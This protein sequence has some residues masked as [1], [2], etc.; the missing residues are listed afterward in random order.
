M[1]P[2]WSVC[3]IAKNE[4]KTLPRLLNSLEEFISLGGEVIL[5]DTGSTDKTVKIAKKAK[6]KV[7]EVGDKFIHYHSD[8]IIDL[9]NK[10][11]VV[12]DEA[13]IM[14]KGS[15]NFDFAAARNYVA[16]L[17]T[18][19]MVAMPDCDEVYNTLNIEEIN[20][21]IDEGVSQFNYH[22]VYAHDEYGNPTIQFYHSKFYDRRKM[23]WRGIV[24]ET[25]YQIGNVGVNM[26]TVEKN[27]IFLEH[28]QNTK[29]YRGQYLTGLAYDVFLNPDNDR[30]SH[31]LGRE[32]MFTNRFNSA[33]KELTRHINMKKWEMERCQ[34][35]LFIGDCMLWLGRAMEALQY[36]HYAYIICSTRREPFLRLAEYYY[37]RQD[38]KR[39]IAYTEASL[40]IPA[41]MFYAVDNSLYTNK[42]HEYLYWAYWQ[43]GEKEKSREHFLKAI[44]YSPNNNKYLQDK[45]W[46][47]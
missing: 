16:S 27:I 38:A 10:K 6:I 15:K 37:H 29:T 47:E 42:P 14:Q 3:L 35:A 25:L 45:K 46:Y 20:K 19:D 30:N 9:I 2:K 24:H 33:I 23:E 40:T 11:F 26:K 39:V 36:Y 31:Y 32:L 18:N 7:V 21:L 8:E 43:I 28:F 1:K 44:N 34:S 41:V 5:L 17:A 13:P 4:E 12:G 22:F